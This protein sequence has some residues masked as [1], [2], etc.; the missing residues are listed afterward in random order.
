MIGVTE[1]TKGKGE[2]ETPTGH[3]YIE[4]I[5]PDKEDFATGREVYYNYC[6]ECRTACKSDNPC[7]CCYNDMWLWLSEDG[8]NEESEDV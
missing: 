6:L 4:Y 5:M 2:D 1:P 7:D 8:R 3:E